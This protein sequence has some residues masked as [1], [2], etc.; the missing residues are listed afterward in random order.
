MS[1]T[2]LL[3]FLSVTFFLAGLSQPVNGARAA[4][5]F[6]PAATIDPTSIAFGYQPVFT[7]SPT[8]TVTVTNNEAEDLILG[9]LTINGEFVLSDNTCDGLTLLTGESCTFKVSFLP[10]SA[11]AKTGEVFI[12]SNSAASPDTVPLSG[13][14]IIG[15][16]ML[17]SPEFDAISTPFPWR[18]GNPIYSFYSV[19]TCK[20]FFSQ[21]C[22]AK[23]IGLKS[24]LA[25]TLSQAV[26][27]GR[28]GL[29]GDKYYLSLA[30]RA[31]NVPAGGQYKFEVVFYDPFNH[32]LLTRTFYFT[33]GTHNWE[34]LGETFTVPEK[35]NM[36]RF[37]ITF[38]NTSGIAWF[39]NAYIMEVP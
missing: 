31:G 25:N 29:A 21:P 32:P 20:V 23:F 1:R 14:G 11:V 39:D 33:P 24:N 10:L 18:V 35:H 16:Q 22:S 28:K 6:A 8:Q 34:T 30:S 3:R 2:S 17:K 15:T 38:Q 19:I 36:I 7:L 9:T 26:Y 13:G 5:G 4:P 12:P 37:V 27:A